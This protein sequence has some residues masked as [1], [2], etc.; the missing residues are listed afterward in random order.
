MLKKSKSKDLSNQSLTGQ[1][2]VA[3]IFGN[4]PQHIS[5]ILNGR[6]PDK[7]GVLTELDLYTKHQQAYIKKRKIILGIS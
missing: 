7:K 6:K 5:D 4:K 3:E 2:I 1:Q